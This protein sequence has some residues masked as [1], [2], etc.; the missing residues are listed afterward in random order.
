MKGEQITNGD[1]SAAQSAGYIHFLLAALFSA[2]IMAGIC[3]VIFFFVKSPV[4]LAFIKANFYADTAD[5]KPERAEKFSYYLLTFLFPFLYTAVLLLIN[6]I[7]PPRISLKILFA[8]EGCLLA[9]VF[10]FVFFHLG[11]IDEGI[12]VYTRLGGWAAAAFF[13]FLSGLCFL[14]YEFKAKTRGAVLFVL[15]AQAAFVFIYV[16]LLYRP[17][18]FAGNFISVW[19]FMPYFA[20]VYKTLSGLAPA[21]DFNNLYGFYPYFYAAAAKVFGGIKLEGFMWINTILIC[22]SLLFAAAAIWLNV[23]NRALRLIAITAYASLFYVF[24]IAGG[25]VYLQF[26]PHRVFFINFIMLLCSLYLRGGSSPRL[27]NLYIA[28]GY[29]AGALA[30]AWNIESGLIA[31][32]AWVLMLIALRVPLVL[33]APKEFW[34]AAVKILFLLFWPC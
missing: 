19:H 25:G 10:I 9:A 21:V 30:V 31:L 33:S 32:W 5:F 26:L 16:L 22:L 27:K 11:F 12:M 8:I 29:G 3:A 7:K 17:P 14:C 20:P 24:N 13:I 6:R 1:A 18:F 34:T 28:V 4:D 23:K 2:L 15:S